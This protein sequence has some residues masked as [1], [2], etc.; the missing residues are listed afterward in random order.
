MP[1]EHDTV[2][3]APSPATVASL[4]AD[5]HA[6]GLRPGM[7]VIVH[8][9]LSQFG[10]VIGGAQAVVL[11]LQQV[12]GE[13]GTLLMPTFST[14]LSE[15]SYWQNPPIPEDWWPLVREHWP[16]FDPHLTPTRMMGAVADVFRVQPDARRSNH[17]ALSFAARGP[18]TAALLDA[19][20]LRDGL[21]ETSPI[22]RLNQLDGHVLL[23]GVGYGNNTSL[24]LGEHRANWPNPPT[25]RQGAPVLVDGVRQWVTFDTLAYNEDDFEQL[26]ADYEA[27][28]PGAVTVGEVA[29]ATARLMRQ[30]PLVDFAANWLRANRNP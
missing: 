11:A 2:A 21:G 16:A 15:P 6:L 24:H 17:P 28:H 14:S 29:Q 3:A 26:G 18:N 25:E 10:W 20:N 23:L 4:T 9:A 7:T 27:A 30:R 13:T 1:T 5:L 22:G 8:S 12:L 19:H